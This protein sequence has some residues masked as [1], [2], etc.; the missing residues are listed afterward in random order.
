MLDRVNRQLL[1]ATVFIFATAA[2]ITLKGYGY[3]ISALVVS[4]GVGSLAIGLGMYATAGG[5]RSRRYSA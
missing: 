3:D 1:I 2:V 4:L 5:R